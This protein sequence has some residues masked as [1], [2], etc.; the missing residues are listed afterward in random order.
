LFKPGD[1]RRFYAEFDRNALMRA[2]SAARAEFISKHGQR[3]LRR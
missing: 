3:V 2:D 1:R